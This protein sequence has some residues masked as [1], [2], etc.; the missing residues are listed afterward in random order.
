[1]AEE[2]G[3][4]TE[5]PTTRRRSEARSRGQVARSTDLSAAVELIGAA[6]VLAAIGGALAPALATILRRSLEDRSLNPAEIPELLLWVAE[7]A[8]WVTVPAMLIVAAIAFAAHLVQ[9]GW[10]ITLQP[11][12]PKLS[13]MNPISGVKRL[14][15]K[16]GMVKAGVSIV[17]VGAL[18]GIGSAVL[19]S[20]LPQIA[21]LPALPLSMALAKIGG[22][23]VILIAWLLAALLVIGLLDFAYQRWQHTHDLRMTRQEVKDERRSMEG[24]PEV[25]GRRMRM[26]REIA[27]QRLG[28]AVPKADVVV[29]NPTHFAVALR[30]DATSMKAPRVTAK[31]ADLLAYRIRQLAA[32]HGVPIVERPALARALYRGVEVGREVRPEH[33]EAVAEILAYVYRV[34]A[35]AA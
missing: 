22:I 20:R 17:K 10:H 30:Y 8:A 33:Y 15:G 21:S 26:A 28:A 7:R 16:R 6:I 23:L 19:W 4:R 5:L 13:K 29:T 35:M 11:L 18:G 25:K 32:L 31:G 9:V 12:T 27:L 2:L 1:M 34:R 3:E 24:D 14:L